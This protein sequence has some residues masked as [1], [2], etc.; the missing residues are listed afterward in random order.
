MIAALVLVLGLQPAHPART[1]RAAARVVLIDESFRDYR[2]L[3]TRDDKAPWQSREILEIS[4]AGEVLHRQ[5]GY[6]FHLGGF[7]PDDAKQ[8]E[9]LAVGKNITGNGLP[10][11]VVSEY[12]GGA[13]CCFLAH[14]FELGKEFRK[15]GTLDARDGD[16]S[17]FEDLDGDGSLEFVTN[18][19]TFAYWHAS[20]ADSPA[21]RVVLKYRDGAYRVA[22]GLMRRPA[23]SAAEL[24][25]QSRE[26]REA[27]QWHARRMPT[28][29]WKTM[30]DLIYEGNADAAWAFLN[31]SWPR[32]EAEK[33]EFRRE[34]LE[35]LRKSP[36]AKEIFGP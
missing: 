36:Y 6:D 17:H 3:V 7:D 24:E 27:P 22:P 1:P 16:L 35:Q 15:V 11:L 5:R 30:L 19:F 8:K 4:R 14:V 20:F 18:D 26:V 10:N 29:L 32:K 25:R 9:L 13:H 28:A 33:E 2:I 31:S 21:P 12:T 34:F 23:P